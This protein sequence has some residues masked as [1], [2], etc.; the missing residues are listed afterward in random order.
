VTGAL[1]YFSKPPDRP[2][3]KFLSE[4]KVPILILVGEY[5][6]PDAHAH[7]GAIQAG[8]PNARRVIISNAGHL[9][10]LEQPQ[11][12]NAS[13]LKFVNNIEFFKILNS[14]GV[15]AAVHYFHKKRETEPGVVLFEEIE[16]NVLGY[17]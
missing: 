3:V 8:I 1:G 17:S 12:F 10:L 14:Q 11:T 5:D 7:S 9:I 4:I 6:I 13:V 16:M 2:A 15:G